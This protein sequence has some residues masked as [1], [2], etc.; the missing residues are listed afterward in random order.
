MPQIHDTNQDTKGT[1]LRAEC[2]ER[3]GG[4]RKVTTSHRQDL[5]QKSVVSRR[6]HQD[7]IIDNGYTLAGGNIAK[8]KKS[9]K[10]TLYGCKWG[11]GDR[12]HY[13]EVRKNV[14]RIRSHTPLGT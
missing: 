1:S 6:I 11:G 12:I 9:P 10:L 5:L 8:H 13:M 7:L 14:V 2:T 4:A 3:Y